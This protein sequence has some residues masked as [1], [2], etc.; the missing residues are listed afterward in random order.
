MSCTNDAML[1]PDSP[2]C[3]SVCRREPKRGWWHTP[4]NRMSCGDCG[5]AFCFEHG[6][7]HPASMGCRRFELGQVGCCN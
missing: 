5:H 7:A 2:Q 4:S 3:A 1:P 6:N